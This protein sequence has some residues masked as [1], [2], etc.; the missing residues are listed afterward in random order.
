MSTHFPLH[1]NRIDDVWATLLGTLELLHQLVQE[2]EA[3]NGA[4]VHGKNPGSKF[5][6]NASKT[7]KPQD[8]TT[9][10]C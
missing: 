3:P 2:A 4:H 7:A 6:Y 5:N 9:S 10:H 8:C 1:F